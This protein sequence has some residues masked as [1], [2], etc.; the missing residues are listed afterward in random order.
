[1]DEFVQFEEQFDK[2]LLSQKRVYVN[3]KNQKSAGPNRESEKDSK[4]KKSSN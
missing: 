3:E 4:S 2:N 1:M